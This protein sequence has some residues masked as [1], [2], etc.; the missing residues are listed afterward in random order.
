MENGAEDDSHI[1]IS[2]AP[3]DEEVEKEKEKKK[4]VEK[5][6]KMVDDE[7]EEE[8]E[9]DD[10]KDEKTSDD[11]EEDDDLN[12]HDE[13]ESLMKNDKKKSKNKRKKKRGTRGNDKEEEEVNDYGTGKGKRIRAPRDREE[14]G[15]MFM[16]WLMI[17]MGY[18]SVIIVDFGFGGYYKSITAWVIVV[19][20]TLVVILLVV[21]FVMVITTDT[22]VERGWA[23]SGVSQEKLEEVKAK[24]VEL[25]EKYKED[26]AAHALSHYENL[27]YCNLCKAYQPIRSHHCK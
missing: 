13:K 25:D 8:E 17:A 18:F 3:E 23:P 6:D 16:I 2:V 20:Y 10:E 27:R 21:T 5:S 14:R 24:S 11:D 15:L 9:D 4:G 19:I 26:K 1:I 22:Y 7:S 12:E